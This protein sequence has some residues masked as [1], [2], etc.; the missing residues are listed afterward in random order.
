[1]AITWTG[2]ITP[3]NIVNYE[4]EISATRVD[5]ITGDTQTYAVPKARIKTAAE[6]LAVVDELW[7]M[8]TDRSAKTTAVGNFVSALEASLKTALEGRE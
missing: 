2:K 7:G 1:M 5:S 4:A 3:L 6:K 8:H